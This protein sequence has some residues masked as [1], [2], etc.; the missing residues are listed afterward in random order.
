MTTNRPRQTVK[1]NFIHNFRH[2]YNYRTTM[3]YKKLKSELLKK[4][5]RSTTIAQ[6]FTT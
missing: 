4:F 1:T 5:R 2:C 6:N 3:Y